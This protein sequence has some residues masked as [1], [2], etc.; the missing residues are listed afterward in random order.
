MS[1]NR[2]HNEIFSILYSQDIII[3][4]LIESF[5]IDINTLNSIHYVPACSMINDYTAISAFIATIMAMIY[6]VGS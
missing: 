4:I 2:T 5:T 1:W 3:Y 6:S